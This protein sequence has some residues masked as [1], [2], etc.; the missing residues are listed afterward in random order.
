MTVVI[1]TNVLP[2]IF[3]A[4]HPY[5]PIAIAWMNGSFDWA[6]STDIL[7]EY[8]EVLGR[9]S[10]PELSRR[11]LTLIE[12]IGSIQQNLRLVSPAFFFRA[13]SADRDDDKFADCAITSNADFIVT[14]DK[15][16]APLI[17]SG[18]RPQPISPARF[19]EICLAGIL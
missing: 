15:H 10:G 16:F 1:D 18:Y 13:I 19:A 14:N 6:V 12:N 8:E 2:G 4:H 3:A 11:I 17:G 7:L 9:L 5:R